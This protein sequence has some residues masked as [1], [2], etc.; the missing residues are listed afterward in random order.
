MALNRNQR[1]PEG[2]RLIEELLREVDAQHMPY[3]RLAGK[4]GG[5]SSQIYS[6]SGL[7]REPMLSSILY[8]GEALGMTLEWRK[9]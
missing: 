2:R 7:K 1:H 4:A 5:S 9:K 6:M 8:L 3:E